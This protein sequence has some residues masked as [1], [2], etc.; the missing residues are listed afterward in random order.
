MSSFGIIKSSFEACQRPIVADFSSFR[1]NIKCILLLF[2]YS[3]AAAA[4]AALPPLP[5]LH[6]R[7]C[8]AV[9][10]SLSLECS[11]TQFV[12]SGRFS[13]SILPLKPLIVNHHNYGFFRNLAETDTKLGFFGIENHKINF[14][15]TFLLQ[16]TLILFQ[17][18]MMTFI[19]ILLRYITFL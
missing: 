1:N 8:R 12:H 4:A 11:P 13:R 18:W 14:F 9:M 5:P 16:K 15:P 7:R 10:Y 2:T 6:Y 19:R 17:I 3:G